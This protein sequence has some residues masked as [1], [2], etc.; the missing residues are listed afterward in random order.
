[1][2]VKQPVNAT[3]SAVT[4]PAIPK[5]LPGWVLRRPPLLVGALLAVNLFRKTKFAWVGVAVAIGLYGWIV[6]RAGASGAVVFGAEHFVLVFLVGAVHSSTSVMRR[7]R[8][9]AA[10]AEIS[11]LAPLPYR[12]PVG[13][14]LAAPLLIQ[15]LVLGVLVAGISSAGRASLHEAGTVW[16]A[17]CAGYLIGGS[18]AAI[19]H[20][21]FRGAPAAG[22]RHAFVHRARI[23]WAFAPKLRPLSYWAIARARALNNPGVS[24]YTMVVVLLGV[25]L[26][27]AGE[28][29]IAIA[30]GWMVGF[31]LVLNLVATVRTAFPAGWWLTPTSVSFGRFALTVP[32]RTLFA[33]AIACVALLVAVGVTGRPR[34]IHLSFIGAGTWL[35]FVTGIALLSCA[36]ALQPGLLPAAQLH[37]RLR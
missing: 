5:G 3:S 23:G 29:V 37:R 17:L 22:S 25:P 36:M 20:S 13:V 18:V 1:V 31:Y 19:I 32:A 33:Q 4:R 16:L 14:R 24:A 12:V 7:K 27:T 21:R 30:G 8:R 26:G 15:L 11:W 34:L 6:T 2:D 10:E 35:A 28:V 9:V